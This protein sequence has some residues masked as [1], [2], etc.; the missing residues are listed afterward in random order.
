MK[1]VG[2]NPFAWS[3]KERFT[4]LTVFPK[5]TLPKLNPTLRPKSHNFAVMK[6]IHS[7]KMKQKN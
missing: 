3:S 5:S 4:P 7:Q 2:V 1:F 6:K